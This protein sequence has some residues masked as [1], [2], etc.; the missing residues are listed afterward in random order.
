VLVLLAL[1]KGGLASAVEAI[2]DGAA[3]KHLLGL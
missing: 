3:G 2:S 1:A